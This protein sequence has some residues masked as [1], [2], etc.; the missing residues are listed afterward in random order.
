MKIYPYSHSPIDFLFTQTP[1]D[2]VVQEIP[3]YPSSG[4]GEHLIIE[5]RKKSLSTPELLKIL[6]S[7]LCIQSREIGYAGLKDKNALTTQYLTIPKSA[8]NKLKYLDTQ[9]IKIL[10]TSLHSNKLRIGH[11]KGNKFF[12]RLKKV[13]KKD[14]QKIS[15][16]LENIKKYGI[17]N[18]FGFQRFG[19]FGDNYLEGKTLVEKKKKIRNKKLALFLIS[20]YQSHLFNLW[21]SQR[22]KLSKLLC[23]FKGKELEIA[24]KLQSLPPLNTI[25]KP[26]EH[27]FKILEGD[28][29]HHYPHGKLFFT[30]DLDSEAQRFVQKNIVPCGIL[31]GKKITLP[32]SDALTYQEAFLD[33]AIYEIGSHRFCWVFPEDL[34]YRYIEEKAH[35]EL[36]FYLPKGSYATI[37]LETLA[38]REIKGENSV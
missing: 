34:E 17:P 7:T 36:N 27:P 13:Q 3:L 29:M 32:L 6:S 37:L 33:P 30:Q 14:L 16:V 22:I 38:N 18:Y 11:L 1:R 21:L 2:F 25:P 4:E 12:I 35:L 23:D 26:Q 31:S 15:Q 8:Q 19:K 28:L 9:N 10:S 5:V 20:S 24:L